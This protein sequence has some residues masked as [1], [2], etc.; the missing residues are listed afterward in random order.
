ML[1]RRADECVIDVYAD[2][3]FRVEALCFNDIDVSCDCT[4]VVRPPT[5]FAGN[6]PFIAANVED[7]CT[8]K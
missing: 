6:Q 4:I 7:T 8:G 3:T 5:Y 2:H 1:P